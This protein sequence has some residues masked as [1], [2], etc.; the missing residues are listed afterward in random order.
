MLIRY[1]ERSMRNKKHRGNLYQS[2]CH[3]SSFNYFSFKIIFAHLQQINYYSR[4]YFRNRYN[5]CV[6]VLFD[7]LNDFCNFNLSI[8]RNMGITSNKLKIRTNIY[9]INISY[10]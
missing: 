8:A 5:A 9:I 3:E 4:G 6:Y 7:V 1:S 2:E 10:T